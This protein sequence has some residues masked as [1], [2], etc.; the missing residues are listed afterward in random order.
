[1]NQKLNYQLKN[2]KFGY[3]Q[4]DFAFVVFIFFSFFYIIFL[5]V[6]SSFSDK[7]LEIESMIN[8]YEANDICNLL[9]SN[10]GMPLDWENDINTIEYFG[11]KNISSNSI[12]SN[13]LSLFTLDNYFILLDSIGFDRGL[14]IEIIGLNSNINYLNF[15]YNFTFDS[16]VS[17]S[18]CF[19]RYNSEMV[20]VLVEV[21]K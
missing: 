8:S 13:K 14:K 11:L 9:I 3:L 4:I 18:S 21:W 6:S 7:D 5:L 10:S 1:M 19:S 15:G 20:M 16:I 2:N 12:N 17:S